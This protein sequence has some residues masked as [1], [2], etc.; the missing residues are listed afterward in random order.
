MEVRET[1]LGGKN[2]ST[3]VKAAARS[4]RVNSK[5]KPIQS[6][7]Y[8]VIADFEDSSFNRV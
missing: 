7:N 5:K 8:E 1:L 2:W 6:A 4:G 3:L